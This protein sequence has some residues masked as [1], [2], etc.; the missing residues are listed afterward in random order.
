MSWDL[1][2]G[3]PTHDEI[4]LGHTGVSF[5]SPKSL[6]WNVYIYICCIYFD[7]SS[8]RVLGRE[9][10]KPFIWNHQSAPSPSVSFPLGAGKN[11]WKL[12]R[13]MRASTQMPSSVPNSSAVIFSLIGPPTHLGTAECGRHKNNGVAEQH[14]PF[15]FVAFWIPWISLRENWKNTLL[16]QY[17]PGIPK[18]TFF[19]VKIVHQIVFSEGSN[20]FRQ[21]ALSSRLRIE[22]PKGALA[23]DGCRAILLSCVWKWSSFR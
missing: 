4:G 11:L 8:S 17:S 23:I 10:F 7:G 22:F 3:G 5:T 1:S 16:S 2:R 15:L 9:Q 6:A 14:E 12:G 18:S 13:C 19:Q 21:M 20:R